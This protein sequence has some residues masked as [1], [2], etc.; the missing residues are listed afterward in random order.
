MHSTMKDEQ[1]SV[2]QASN[3]IVFVVEDKDVLGEKNGICKK[4]RYFEQLIAQ[5]TTDQA[6]PPL[7]SHRKSA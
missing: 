7:Q 1:K 6:S 2:S 5:F 3:M 4:S